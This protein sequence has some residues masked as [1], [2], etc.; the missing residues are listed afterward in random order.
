MGY[1][2]PPGLEA[3]G[4][5]ALARS[6]L[7]RS[8]W[9][10]TL[11]RHP[12][13]ALALPTPPGRTARRGPTLLVDGEHQGPVAGVQLHEHGGLDQVLG[14]VAQKRDGPARQA[15]RGHGCAQDAS[16]NT[17]SRSGGRLIISSS[18]G[19]RPAPHSLKTKSGYQC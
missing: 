6:P 8:W 19:T 14:Q 3:G 2:Q 16:Q 18:P 7:D 4:G 5:T 9:V 12:Q 17:A 11:G 1:S 15:T 10:L 13:T